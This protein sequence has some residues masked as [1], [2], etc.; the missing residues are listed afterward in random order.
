MVI[1]PI[2]EGHDEFVLII[3]AVVDSVMISCESNDV[4]EAAL[5]LH[6]A[7]AAS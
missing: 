4:D 5:N 2:Y 3:D 6:I 1:P 7:D